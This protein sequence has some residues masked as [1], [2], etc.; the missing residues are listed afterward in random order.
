MKTKILFSLLVIFV[1]NTTFSQEYFPLVKEN[2]VWNI[3]NVN[4]AIDPW[5][6]DSYNTNSY[7]IFGDTTIN[8]II[9]KKL[10]F[11]NCF[12]ETFNEANSNYFAAIREDDKKVYF[13]KDDEEYIIYDFSLEVGE[14]FLYYSFFSNQVVELQVES[15][16]TILVNGENRNKINFIINDEFS[17][18]VKSWVEGIGSQAGLFDYAF[19]HGNFDVYLNCYK[20]NEAIIYSESGDNCCLGLTDI[21]TPLINVES[22]NI[23][24]NPATKVLNIV[25]SGITEIQ[26]IDINGN[27]I[28]KQKLNKENTQIDIQQFT[29]GFY[30]LRVFIDQ[31]VI[32][33]KLMVV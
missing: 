29:K 1:A 21:E 16:E 27:I 9:Y 25:G 11:V 14:T 28:Y 17:G 8:T 12:D 6:S 22:L 33:K 5:D 3:T 4:F 31:R 2:A 13:F 23:F 19:Y 20:E 18:W 32:T 26:I 10:W 7:R 15:I 24:P 30:L